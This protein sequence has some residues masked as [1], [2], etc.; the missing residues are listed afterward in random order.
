MGKF[1]LVF[2]SFWYIWLLENVQQK[3]FFLKKDAEKIELQYFRSWA[4]W[5]TIVLTKSLIFIFASFSLI[6]S[7]IIIDSDKKRYVI[8]LF[9]THFWPMF[10]FY[11]HLWFSGVF[12]GY[13]M[14]TLARNGLKCI[15]LS[16][17]VSQ[18]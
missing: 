8:S 9:L 16:L 5:M 4:T 12:R 10:P 1:F 13:K 7:L 3:R 15:S 17:A 6:V 11:T 14:G 2:R 18:E